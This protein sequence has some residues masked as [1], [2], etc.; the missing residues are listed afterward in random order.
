[1]TRLARFLLTL[2]ATCVAGFSANGQE[3]A[4]MRQMGSG[5]KEWAGSVASDGSGGLFLPGTTTK[6]FGLYEEYAA[7]ISR[8]DGAGNPL[9]HR[10][11][12]VPFSFEVIPI[13][14]FLSAQSRAGPSISDGAGGGFVSGECAW[15]SSFHFSD[16]WIG[17]FRGDGEFDWIRMID[18]W[19]SVWTTGL[20]PDGAGG[21]FVC[22]GTEGRLGSPPLGEGDAWLARFDSGG[23]QLWIRQF[24]TSLF[25]AS[26]SCAADGL[27]GVFVTGSTAGSL[28]GPSGGSYDGWLARFDSA[29]N[30]LWIVQFG[31]AGDEGQLSASSDGLGGVFLTGQIDMREPWVARFDSQGNQTWW[32][33]LGVYP[34]VTTL[35]GGTCSDGAGGAFVLGSTGANLGGVNLG[36]FDIWLARYTAD[37]YQLFRTQLG[38]NQ[39]DYAWAP[40]PDGTG[41]FF[42]SGWTN[43]S[44]AGPNGGSYD[45]WVGRW[46][47]S[48]PAPVA[49]CTAKVNSVGC[50]PAI[51]ALGASSASATAGFAVRATNVV[52]NTIG[53]LTCTSE[54][55]DALPFQGGFLCLGAPIRRTTFVQS[56]GNPGPSDCSGVYALDLN[57][58]GSGALGGTPAPYLVMPGTIVDVQWWGRDPGFPAPGNV[59]L[60]NALEFIVFP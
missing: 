34:N 56:G 57:A 54:G 51:E 40:M 18:T 53:L 48:F 7:W 19:A 32:R 43:G 45:A 39:S 59:A 12:P 50:T 13:S 36:G 47:G 16:G 1:M 38:T 37:G 41:G 10:R 25:E 21:A 22:G 24:G 28:G 30:R 6:G 23:H 4:W 52:N 46:M 17:H 20:A 3:L 33:S 58:F 49:Y 42:C 27:G 35:A 29:G 11:V 44:L 9:W 60:S 5:T 14:P 55:R 15:N 2:T 8:W 31:G 26:T